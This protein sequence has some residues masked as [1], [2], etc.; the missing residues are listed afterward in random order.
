MK[1]TVGVLFGG[2]SVENEISVVTALQTIEAMDNTK[3]DIVPIYIAKNGKWYSG[4]QFLQVA[5]YRNMPAL[6]KRKN[7]VFFKV[8]FGEKTLYRHRRLKSAVA[9]ID[10]IL[11]CLHGTNC[12]DGT[13]QGLLDVIGMPYVGCNTFA[14]ANGMDKISMKQILSSS[15]IPVVDFEW[16]SDK[17]WDENRDKIVDRIEKNLEY[18]VIVKPSNSGSSVGISPAHNRED[19]EEAIDNAA[20]FTTRIIVE[21][22]LEHLKEVNCSVYGDYY[23]CTP[24]VCEVPM[25]SGEILTY[26]DKYMDGGAKGGAKGAKSGGCKGGSKLSGCKS[27][28]MRSTKREL[29]AN[30]PD[31]EAQLIRNMAVKT[32]RTLG[33]EGVSRIDFMIDE[34]DR[35][36]YVNE[37][38]TI[39]GSLSSYLWDYTGIPF[40]QLVDKLIE[41]AFARTREAGFKVV[42]FGGNIFAG[43]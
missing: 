22:M 3:Y 1:T 23:E 10:V 34:V 11:P 17:D 41:R 33:C 21:R 43:R 37:I 7:E 15:G 20:Q 36:V 25:R 8:A 42:D 24:S 5:N 28:G 19:L 32:F 14:S 26:S 40:P 16:F 30:I 2:R 39:P 35:R 27:E 12:E 4:E 6:L 9:T 18:P 38:N 29:P 31:N 13:V